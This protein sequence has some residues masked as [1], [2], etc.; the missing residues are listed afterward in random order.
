MLISDRAEVDHYLLNLGP[1]DGAAPHDRRLPPPVVS[2]A[3]MWEGSH[4]QEPRS[5]NL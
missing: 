4:V 5:A 1:A 2:I 3:P